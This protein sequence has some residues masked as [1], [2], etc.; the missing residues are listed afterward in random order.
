MVA[1]SS[2]MTPK[3]QVAA[4]RLTMRVQPAMRP[5]SRPVPVSLALLCTD[6]E[7]FTPLVER[8]GDFAA[9]AVMRAHNQLL[10][11]CLRSCDGREVAHTGDG[12]L[13]SFARVEHA[14]QCAAA[15]QLAL[16]GYNATR[17]HT[18]L[19]VRIGL[20]VGTPL[21]EEGRLFGACVNL[22][23]RVCDATACER[24]YASDAF[25]RVA[26]CP[27]HRWLDRGPFALK[28]IPA[29]V[30]LHELLFD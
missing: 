3:T 8:L 22:T 30:R 28:G 15:M 27:S 20:H 6:L 4:T 21:P 16:R 1:F 12:I 10:R 19:R 7:G 23:V 5:V 29:A 9:R 17:E 13:A 25:R 2:A 24:I 26:T 14:L 11:R 18:P